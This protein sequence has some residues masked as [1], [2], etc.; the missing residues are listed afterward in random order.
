MAGFSI[1]FH[2]LP[3]EVS[4]LLNGLLADRTIHV[5]ELLRE[6][7]GIR[8]L[9]RE[10]V[11]V[12]D[13]RRRALLFTPSEPDLTGS[14]MNAPRTMDLTSLFWRSAASQPMD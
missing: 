12:H 14:D 10:I 4:L 7:P 2:A 3:E 8:A 9:N 13:V 1:Q 6:P 5:T 11:L